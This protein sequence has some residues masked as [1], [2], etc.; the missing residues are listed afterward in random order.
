M[1]CMA[2]CPW[3]AVTVMVAV[4]TFLPLTS[5]PPGLEF[6]LTLSASSRAIAFSEKNLMDQAQ[7]MDSSVQLILMAHIPLRW[8]LMITLLCW[9]N[10][11]SNMELPPIWSLLPPRTWGG[12]QGRTRMESGEV[13]RQRDKNCWVHFHTH[14]KKEIL[15]SQEDY[16]LGQNQC[17]PGCSVNLFYACYILT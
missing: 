1:L 11:L 5:L 9:P 7:P 17:D 2:V 8:L 3:M 4:R 15:F 6:A 10:N 13:V 12:S 14:N 16:K